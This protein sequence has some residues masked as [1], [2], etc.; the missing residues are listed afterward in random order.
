MRRGFTIIELLFVILILGV[1]AA[2]AVPKFGES[3]KQSILFDAKSKVSA[4]RSALEVYK[5]RHVL[6]GQDPYPSTLDKNG[7]L[8]N[9]VLPEGVTPGSEP[10]QWSSLGN[11]RYK[12]IVDDNEYAVFVYDKRTG[13][14]ECDA[15]ASS[16]RELCKHF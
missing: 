15:N 10:G 14:F 16:P 1:L 9:V 5:T 6:L 11:N 4:I 3:Y 7:K 12:F 13:K 2:I 8:F